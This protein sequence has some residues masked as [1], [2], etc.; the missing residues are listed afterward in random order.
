MRPHKFPKLKRV[1][2][3][4]ALA[5]GATALLCAAP[6][7]A[8]S[9]LSWLGGSQGA[10]WSTGGDWSGGSAPSGSVATLTLPPLAGA[11]NGWSCAYGV[12]DIPTLTVGA[13]QLDATSGYRVSPLEAADQIGL[14]G[15]LSFGGS[16]TTA[17]GGPL[18]TFF[19][20]PL[21]LA[22]AQSWSLTGVPGLATTLQLGAVTGTRFALRA[23][24]ANGVRLVS[25]ELDTGPL[26][27][28][29][30]GTVAL[31]A[32]G[33]AQP[34]DGIAVAPPPLLPGA[35]VALTG[36]ASLDV[37]SE[38]TVSG[39][40]TVAP[41][42]ASTLTLGAGSAPAATMVSYGD[43]TLRPSATLALWLDA[44]AASARAKP[45]P[46]GDYSQLRVLGDLNLGG[47]TLTLTHGYT[48]TQ[49]PCA[50]LTP[51]Q[52]YT[53]LLATKLTGTFA[54]IADGQAVELGA[55][56]PLSPT[57]T[58]LLIHY[59]TASHPQT[60]TATVIG[61][62][63]IRALVTAALALPRAGVTAAGL[64][65]AGGYSAVYDAPA[66]GTLALTW[67]TRLH[68][69]LITVAQASNAAGQAGP[70]RLPV[71]LTA[72][73]RRLLRTLARTAPRRKPT[74]GRRARRKRAPARFITLTATATLTPNTQSPP[75]LT[76]LT[77]RR[78]VR[79]S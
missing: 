27:L 28:A 60:V 30:P 22:A 66:P 70:R 49:T 53:L 35:G 12:D 36:G 64:L 58:A 42:S 41:G 40:I 55:C 14:T 48:D 77:V 7:A 31:S 18:D 45:V 51:G 67:T 65:R 3:A 25:P 71:R 9:D 16:A 6:A 50:A 24:L 13:L 20:V 10:D 33:A 63:Q 78:P 61:V 39:P 19:T 79:I 72:A 34:A 17:T 47:A 68:G 74:H 37:T 43:V 57:P 15:G 73:G 2:A 52:T 32:T 5:A 11:C 23:N 76:P 59:N 62:P 54:G 44:P 56:D 69:H 75:T 1:V 26:T 21:T 38:G 29:G 8:A 46:G 4:R